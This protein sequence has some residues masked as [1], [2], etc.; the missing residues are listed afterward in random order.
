MSRNVGALERVVRI[1]IGV[2]LIALGLFHV[3]SG[4][5]AIA[6]YVVGAIALVTG[7]VRYCP[8]WAIFGI[9]AS[10]TNRPG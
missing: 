4:T 9:N 10:T 7:F 5:L 2:A 8:A 3:F 6:G 1:F